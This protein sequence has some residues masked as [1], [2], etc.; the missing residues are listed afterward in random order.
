MKK[1]FLLWLLLLFYLTKIIAQTPYYTDSLKQKLASVKE[2]T[3]KVNLLFNLAITYLFAYADTSATYA[4]QNGR[5][6]ISVKD[7]GNGIPQKVVDKIFQP[8][9][10]TKPTGKGTGLGLS[11]AYDLIKAHGGEITDESKE[12]Q[13]SIFKIQLKV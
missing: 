13:R 1:I 5:I 10:T 4:K 12:E 8:F 9:F 3:A 11:L 2:D 6:E 7:N